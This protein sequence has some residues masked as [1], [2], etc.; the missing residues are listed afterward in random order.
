MLIAGSLWAG[1]TKDPF[2]APFQDDFVRFGMG[3]GR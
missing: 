3:V 2:G 1:L